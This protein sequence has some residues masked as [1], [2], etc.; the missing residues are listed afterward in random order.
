MN[1]DPQQGGLLGFF[2]RMR[3]PNE[4]TGLSPFQRF[5]AALDPLIL[6]EMRAGQQ[7][8]EQGAQRVAQGNKN[9]TIAELE[10]M[11]ASGNTM[12]AQ[13]LSAVKAGAI[14]PAEAYKQLITTQYDTS[15]SIIRA[16]ERFPNGAY[17]VVTDAGRKV[18][19][20]QGELV[21][22][23]EAAKTL[24]E[25]QESQNL[26]QAQGVGLSQA[27]KFQAETVKNAFE[28]ADQMT[29]SI[30]SVDEAIRSIDAGAPRGV[31]FNLLPNI[32]E[33]SASLDRALKQMGLDIVGS[34]TF[35]ALSAAELQVAMATA[36]PENAPA[37]ELRKFL[38]RRKEALQKLRSYTEEAAMFLSNPNNTANDWRELVIE[39]RNQREA[40][41]GG[42]PY[43][44][45]DLAA[46]NEAFNNR[47]SLNEAQ[48]AQL[49]EALRQ[50]Q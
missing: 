48:R 30:A 4:Q 6:P 15:G 23:E 12:A 27:Q 29:T 28:K 46:L 13:L 7:I 39:R 50:R 26:L 25:A 1:P 14:S 10:K 43:L 44:D 19:N 37:P 24:L 9:R 33:Q 41:V 21:T 47:A 20:P 8:R 5:G 42:N 36:Y 35:G 40:S 16:T 45:M 11:A 31:F 38:V 32:T 3:K 49:I 2:Q 17:Y 22:G 34:V 18:Y